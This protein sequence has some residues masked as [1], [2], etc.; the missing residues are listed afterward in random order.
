MYSGTSSVPKISSGSKSRLK[1]KEGESWDCSREQE[2]GLRRKITLEWFASLMGHY[3]PR[4]AVSP[5]LPWP[6]GFF[7][8][9]RRTRGREMMEVYASGFAEYQGGYFIS[10]ESALGVMT[11]WRTLMG[12]PNGRVS[13]RMQRVFHWTVF[14]APEYGFSADST[15]R[16]KSLCVFG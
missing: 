2:K 15:P 13:P 10:H 5:C 6:W 8:W 12:I 14:M 11:G 16:D 3:S 4:L 9:R 7:L 1:T